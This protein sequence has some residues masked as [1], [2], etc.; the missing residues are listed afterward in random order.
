MIKVISFTFISLCLIMSVGFYGIAG[1]DD[2][3]KEQAEEMTNVSRTVDINEDEAAE[4]GEEIIDEAEM[5][6]EAEE[7]LEKGEMEDDT[8]KEEAGK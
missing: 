2:T 5:K 1:A 7:I 8:L 4:K 3:M 6:E